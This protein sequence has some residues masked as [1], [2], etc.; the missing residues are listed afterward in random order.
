MGKQR[1]FNLFYLTISGAI[2]AV[3]LLQFLTGYWI[4]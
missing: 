4:V 3:L 2:L 1:H